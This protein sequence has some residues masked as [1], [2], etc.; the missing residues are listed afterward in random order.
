M[1]GQRPWGLPSQS[2]SV[3]LFPAVYSGLNVPLAPCLSFPIC[4]PWM[5]IALYLPGL[6]DQKKKL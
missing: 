4:E 2:D 5:I 6:L 1:T 3:S